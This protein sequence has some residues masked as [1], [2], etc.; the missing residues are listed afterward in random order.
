MVDIDNNSLVLAASSSEQG[1]GPFQK[2]RSKKNPD[3]RNFFQIWN[4]KE[5]VERYGRGFQM[6][7]KRNHSNLRTRGQHVPWKRCK[8]SSV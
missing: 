2:F 4:P 6:T 5:R 1:K 8:P 3:G 7:Q